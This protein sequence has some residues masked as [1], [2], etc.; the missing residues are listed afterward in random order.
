MSATLE[1]GFHGRYAPECQGG[2]SLGY[3]N[4]EKKGYHLDNQGYRRFFLGQS[5]THSAL[6]LC[7][8]LTVTLSL[9]RPSHSASD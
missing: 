3:H 1:S 9:G 7:Q 2:H 5:V 8:S 4:R 6:S